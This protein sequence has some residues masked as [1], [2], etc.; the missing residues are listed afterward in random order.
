MKNDDDKSY[1][2]TRD[3]ERLRSHLELFEEQ[4]KEEPKNNVIPFPQNSDAKTD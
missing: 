3:N 2:P 1:W 4:P